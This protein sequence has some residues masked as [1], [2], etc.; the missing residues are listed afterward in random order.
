MAVIFIW[1]KVLNGGIWL[2]YWSTSSNNLGGDTRR[3]G[4]LS[5]KDGCLILLDELSLYL[6]EKEWAA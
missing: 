6:R 4:R 2:K 3:K 1:L 5:L